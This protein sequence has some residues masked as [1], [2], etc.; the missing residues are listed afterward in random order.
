MCKNHEDGLINYLIRNVFAFGQGWF[1]A[2]AS[3]SIGIILVYTFG[4]SLQAHR[5][6]FWIVTPLTY[7]WFL[8]HNR[9]T[10][11]PF[12]NTLGLI[13]SMSWALAGAAGSSLQPLAEKH[14]WSSSFIANISF[15]SNKIKLFFLRESF[16]LWGSSKLSVVSIFYFS[17]SQNEIRMSRCFRFDLLQC[18]NFCFYVP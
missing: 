5:I 7:F 14:Q 13:V 8:S 6:F 10:Y 1:I 17:I 16:S 4:M 18:L 12:L 11:P 2:A 9:S 15:Y 3:L